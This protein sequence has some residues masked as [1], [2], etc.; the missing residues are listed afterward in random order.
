MSEHPVAQALTREHR[1]IDT[2]IEAFVTDVTAGVIAPEAI[3]ATFDSLR[4][5]IWLEEEILFPPV[6]TGGLAMPVHVMLMEHGELWRVMDEVEQQALA[7]D[8][9]GIRANCQRLLE[10]L[11]RHNMKEEPV[12]YGR[13]PE[14]LSPEELG[15]LAGALEQERAPQGWVCARAQK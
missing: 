9:D 13:I 10:L 2:A 5:H 8:E 3:T 11:D 12:I 6:G 7:E 14:G 4:R 1:D 15:A